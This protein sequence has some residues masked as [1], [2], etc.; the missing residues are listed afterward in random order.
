MFFQ[1]RGSVFLAEYSSAGTQ[2]PYK[3]ELCPDLFTVA[4]AQET[5]SHTSKCGAVDVEDFRGTKSSSGTVNLNFVDV[6]DKKF[7]LGVFG[8]VNAA[9]TAG[10]VTAETLPSGVAVGDVYFCGGATRNR[11]ITTLVVTDSTGSPVTLVLNTDYTLDAASGKIK[12]LTI[13][14]TQPYK[15]AY[16]YTN[17]A[18]VS[19]L[20]AAAKEYVLMFENINKAD[21]N[22]PGSFELYRVKF[23]PAQNLDFLSDELQA[24]ELVGSV[25]ADQNR[26][27]TDTVLGQFG[28]RV[29]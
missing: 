2:A 20:T 4:L 6:E 5:F 27:T 9:G 19:L 24:M 13:T 15:L 7:A 10:T 16:G 23:D 1:G 25:L 3:V 14:G 17:P 29:L 26:S 12:F 21:S 22:N 28:R 18:A 11:A 8:T